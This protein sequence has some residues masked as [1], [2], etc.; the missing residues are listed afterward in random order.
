[1]KKTPCSRFHFEKLRILQL[2]EKVSSFYGKRRSLSF[3]ESLGTAACYTSWRIYGF[4]GM[5]VIYWLLMRDWTSHSCL[6][7][8]QVFLDVTMSLNWR[9]PTFSTNIV[10][11]YSG[12]G[13][14]VTV[15]SRSSCS[16]TPAKFFGNKFLGNFGKHWIPTFRLNPED[17][18]PRRV[19][20]FLNTIKYL[21]GVMFNVYVYC[22][23]GN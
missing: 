11:S 1:V 23:V 7:R 10:P 22:D 19:I 12:F 15:L 21:V 5:I 18:S 14:S 4:F 8:I 16:P 9:L 6:S 3:S 20:I 17:Q 13:G 2:V